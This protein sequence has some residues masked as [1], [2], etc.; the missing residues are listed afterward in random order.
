[1]KSCLYCGCKLSDDSIVDFCEKCGV[2]VFGHKM[3]KVIVKN[4]SQAK[5][6]DNLYQ[7]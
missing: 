4:M 6:N 5:E 3:F 1:M 7:S 2:G